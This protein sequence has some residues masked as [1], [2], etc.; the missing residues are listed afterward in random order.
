MTTTLQD[1]FF[2]FHPGQ[3]HGSLPV[4]GAREIAFRLTGAMEPDVLV[5]CFHGATDRKKIALPRFQAALD[6]GPLAAYL[7]ICDPT[8]DAH[9]ALRLG[10]Y[11]GADNFPLRSILKEVLHNTIAKLRPRRILFF[12]GSGGGYAALLYARSVA[13]SVSL[14]INPQ[15][16]ILSYYSG[17]VGD[18]FETCWPNIPEVERRSRTVVSDLAEEYQDNPGKVTTV[19]LSSA[20]DRQHFVNHVSRFVGR[21]GSSTRSRLILASDFFGRMGHGGSIPP[22]VIQRWYNAVLTAETTEPESIL[23]AYHR[24]AAVRA[25]PT[26]GRVRSGAGPDAAEI[27]MADLLRDY[28]LRQPMEV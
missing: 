8:L 12:G 24:L 11:S 16:D 21:V 15:T 9:E 10:W 2:Q 7:S 23:M 25:L 26:E 5:I 28:H 27:G 3:D 4:G 6:A 1:T 20:G 17:H 22:D 13:G 19:M 14:T 18:Y